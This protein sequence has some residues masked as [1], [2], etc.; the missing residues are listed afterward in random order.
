M[1]SRR[2][3]LLVSCILGLWLGPA[4]S[5]SES[6][7]AKRQ[8]RRIPDL[9]GRWVLAPTTA[10]V[11]S[12]QPALILGI[13][14]E[15]KVTQDAVSLIVEHRANSASHPRPGIYRFGSRLEAEAGS[16]DPT[17]S[18]LAVPR[19]DVTEPRGSSRAF[20]GLKCC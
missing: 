8:T 6:A 11:P 4:G 1:T 13:A 12:N 19:D 10:V 3:L 18:G 7:A 5:E 16:R 2:V 9:S 20:A 15:L 14:N 17:R